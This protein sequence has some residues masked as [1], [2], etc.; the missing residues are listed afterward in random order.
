MVIKVDKCNE[1]PLIFITEVS[2]YC[3]HPI[4][5]NEKSL[6]YTLQIEEILDGN[7][8]HPNCP[9]RNECISI[10]IK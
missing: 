7:I 5:W 10:R 8:M 3:G 2:Q 4:N 9:L 1:C 6:D